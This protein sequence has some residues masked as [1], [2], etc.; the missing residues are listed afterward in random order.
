MS[1]ITLTAD[2]FD[3]VLDKNEL[4][5]IDFW[6]EWCAPCKSFSK[7]IEQLSAKHS[8]VVFGSVDIDKEKELAEDF[9]IMSVPSV[10]IL[11]RRVIVFAETGALTEQAMQDLLHQAKSLD[12]KQLLLNKKPAE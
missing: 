4:V 7:V 8:D 1:A 11:R 6:A 3:D 2:N 9:H 5:V 10:M 12:E